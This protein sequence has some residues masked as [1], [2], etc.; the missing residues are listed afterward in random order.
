MS[1]EEQK[2]KL[3]SKIFDAT[4]A[5]SLQVEEYKDKGKNAAIIV[6][7]L[8]AAYTLYSLLASDDDDSDNK[9]IVIIPPTSSVLGTAFSGIIS[10][11]LLN[12]AKDKI[13]DIIGSPKV[14][15]EE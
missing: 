7:I 13:K 10:S 15:N 1:R 6:G 2:S 12:F 8:F 4:E 5:L 11:V 14:E 9:K 3:E